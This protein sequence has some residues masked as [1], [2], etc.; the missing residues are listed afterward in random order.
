MFLKFPAL[1]LSGY[2]K[3]LRYTHETYWWAGVSWELWPQ[4][5]VLRWMPWASAAQGKSE[6][7]GRAEPARRRLEAFCT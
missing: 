5:Q 6:V 2:R 3:S 7:Q 4:H 1:V